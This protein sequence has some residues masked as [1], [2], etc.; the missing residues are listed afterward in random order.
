MLC[1]EGKWF[2]AVFFFF[3]FFIVLDLTLG[4][5]MRLCSSDWRELGPKALKAGKRTEAGTWET[6]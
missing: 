1:V 2:E 6:V 3:F 4:G 5:E